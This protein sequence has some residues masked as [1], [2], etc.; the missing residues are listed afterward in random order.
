LDN[1]GA[2]GAEV[3][4]PLHSFGHRKYYGAPA[5]ELVRDGRAA[6]ENPGRETALVLRNLEGDD[7]LLDPKQLAIKVTCT[8]RNLPAGM[9]VG[10]S[11]GDLEALDTEINCPIVL[12]QQPTQSHWPKPQHG[13]WWQLLSQLTPHVCR[14]DQLGLNALKELFRPF[15]AHTGRRA[16]HI[17]GMVSLRWRSVMLWTTVAGIGSLERGVEITVA[18]DEQRFESDSVS[19]FIGVM[20]RFFSAYVQINSSIQLVAVS[21]G[22]GAV[23]CK[24]PPRAGRLPLI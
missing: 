23:I 9:S 8:N 17:E 15:A 16:V 6:R 11:S 13:Y 10:T 24:C 2:S 5:W 20:D 3:I 19:T 21:A 4:E 14:L 22:T 12:L 18:L 1:G 7:V